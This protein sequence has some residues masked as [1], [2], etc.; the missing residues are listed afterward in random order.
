MQRQKTWR[1]GWRLTGLIGAALVV[2]AG[3]AYL[4]AD[5]PVTGARLAIRL[6][7]RT[8]LMLFLAAFTAAALFRLFP[9]GP[10]RWLRV[11][12]RYL[13]VSFAISHLVHLVAI[14]TLARLDPVVFQQLTN[15][16]SFIGGGLA[17][18]FILLMAATS[19]DRSAALIGPRAWRWLHL[20]GGWYILLSFALNF[21]KR[22][23]ADPRYLL[24]V[25]VIGL[26]VAIRLWGR[27]RRQIGLDPVS[28]TQ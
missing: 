20:S 15:I 5:D 27:P 18:V 2:M 11:N 9:S 14:I 13:G 28:A 3:A 16:V 7:A 17:Y 26:A 6:T 24:P 23:P 10:T 4:Q 19:F 21:G 1:G 25:A 22:A 12:R 8:S